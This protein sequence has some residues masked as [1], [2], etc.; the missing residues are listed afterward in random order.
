MAITIIVPDSI[1]NDLLKA[2]IDVTT[3]NIYV[4]LCDNTYVPLASHSFKSD[5]TG[6]IT[7]VD[8]TAGGKLVTNPT[9][10]NG[11]FD[12]S[13]TIWAS[14][15]LSAR[16]AVVYKSTGVAATSPLIEIMDFGMTKTSSHGDF[17]IIWNA[18]GILR[19]AK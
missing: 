7:D 5:V 12:A 13:D 16:Y 10:V 4:M 1:L 19:L 11:Y 18:S 3:D 14:S 15:Y 2:K 8:Y 9:V 6:E 17:K